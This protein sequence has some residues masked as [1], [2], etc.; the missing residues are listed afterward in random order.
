MIK[1][2][3]YIGKEIEPFLD[4][5]SEWRV[6]FFKEPPYLYVGTIESDKEHTRDYLVDERSTVAIAR[7][8]DQI[9]GISTGIPLN[10]QSN[11][12]KVLQSLFR[13]NHKD[14]SS[15]Y[16]FGEVMI[17]PEYRGQGLT[18]KLFKAQE[19]LAVQWGYQNAALLTV[20]RENYFDLDNMWQHLGYTK[21][22]MELIVNWPTIQKDGSV[23]NSD[24]RMPVWIKKL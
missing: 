24:N 7:S 12:I 20:V 15:Y 8:E 1:I 16:Y 18:R 6:K 22:E 19:K 14:P 9:V 2:D 17:L 23:R 5:L 3:V 4:L 10:S 11:F 13:S 21:T